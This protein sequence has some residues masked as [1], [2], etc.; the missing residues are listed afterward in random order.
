[1]HVFFVMTAHT[2]DGDV[3]C[4]IDNA[5][6]GDLIQM[7]KAEYLEMPGLCLTLCQAQRLWNLDRTTCAAVLDK[8]VEMRFLTRSEAGI[9]GRNV[10]DWRSKSPARSTTDSGGTVRDSSPYGINHG[11]R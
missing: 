5:D 6:L 10:S 9:Y 3:P 11:R 4:T 2:L 7:V 1:L 8:L